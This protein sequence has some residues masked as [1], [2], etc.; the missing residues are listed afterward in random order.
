MFSQIL[1]FFTFIFGLSGPIG[2]GSCIYYL[3]EQYDELQVNNLYIGVIISCVSFGMITLGLCGSKNNWLWI[4]GGGLMI[5]SFGYNLYILDTL[6]HPEL[7][8]FRSYTNLYL[9]YQIVLI[10]SSVNSLY[11]IMYV[12]YE[13]KSKK[14]TINN[15]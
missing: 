14:K 10:V 6:S 2:L 15:E 5:P 13:L 8:L 3:A 1:T 7:E 4:I 9:F 12:L 11:I